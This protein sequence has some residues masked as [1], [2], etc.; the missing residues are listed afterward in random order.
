M[1]R[2]LDFRPPPAAARVPA[3]ARPSG[4][5]APPHP[6]LCGCP[7]PSHYRTR[8]RP[9]PQAPE[10]KP[11]L[12]GVR[13]PGPA[14][15]SGSQEGHGQPVLAARPPRAS[16]RAP[17]RPGPRAPPRPVHHEGRSPPAPPPRAHG[18]APPQPPA[19]RAAPGDPGSRVPRPWEPT[20]PPPLQRVRGARAAVGPGP[21]RCPPGH[22]RAGPRGHH[23]APRLAGAS[24]PGR[25]V[26]RER[27]QPRACSGFAALAPQ[28][29]E[30]WSSS[31]RLLRQGALF[32][33]PA[34]PAP[35]AER[36]KPPGR[37]GVSE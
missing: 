15:P 18:H 1:R 29:G 4:P 10:S 35:L 16:G 23:L 2:P 36:I 33:L 13:Q 11:A 6:P 28:A 19:E 24:L 20:S 21:R 3:E 31:P 34:R 26:P 7:A 5:R 25:R 32:L 9:P 27:A 30:Q 37:R 22:D 8:I 14:G 17:A 12:P